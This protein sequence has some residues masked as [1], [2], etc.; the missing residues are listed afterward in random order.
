[1][2]G[3][4]HEA[5][6]TPAALPDEGYVALLGADGADLD[7]LAALAD[8]LRQQSVGDAI[9]YVANRNL[10]TGA[11]AGRAPTAR[12]HLAELVV[13]ARELGATEICMQGPLPA[14]AD[15]DY[16]ELIAAIT[17]AAPI[18]LHA[19]RV[20][21]LLDGAARRRL[22]LPQFLAAAAAA[23][24]RSV[25]GT[26]ARILDDD[27]RT[28][29]NDGPDTPVATWINV[30]EAAHRAGLRS[31]STMV[32]GHIETPAQQVAHL[33]TL[34]AIQART[35]GFTEFIAMPIVPATMP[36]ALRGRPG[37]R[38]SWRQTRALYAVARLILHGRIDNLQVAW[39]K[40]G[41][42]AAVPLLGGGANDLGGLLFDGRLDPA[43][44]AEAGKTL[45]L[46]TIETIAQ[47]LGR[48]IRQRTTRYEDV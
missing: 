24:L 1:V 16:I 41:L 34:A 28:R 12:H 36:P 30:I 31:T 11:V 9:S 10:D 39:P 13:E 48:P 7:A 33:R 21:E 47:R 37:L 42:A 38:P 17:A 6:R 19:F 4:L 15:D 29:M 2:R 32:Y 3:W 26:A 23:G 45:T 40:L 25:P 35:G 44:G 27:V 43:A 22:T 5:E 18:H 14:A 8:R 20:E 46:S